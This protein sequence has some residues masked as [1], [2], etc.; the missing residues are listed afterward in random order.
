LINGLFSFFAA[1]GAEIRLRITCA[2]SPS[3]A[4]RNTEFV[5]IAAADRGKSEQLAGFQQ[6]SPDDRF[7][8][9]SADNS[10][11]DVLA[12]NEPLALSRQRVRLDNGAE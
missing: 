2:Q 3:P 7:G 5:A 4:L 8:L 1:P 9:G 6:F 11:G 10:R 12:P